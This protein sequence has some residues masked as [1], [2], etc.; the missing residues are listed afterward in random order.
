MISFRLSINGMCWTNKTDQSEDPIRNLQDLDLLL[1]FWCQIPQNMSCGVHAATNYNWF[2]SGHFQ[3]KS[4][5]QSNYF[6]SFSHEFSHNS[7]QTYLHFDV[8]ITLLVPYGFS[9]TFSVEHLIQ[10]CTRIL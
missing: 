9:R 3:L 7:L 6:Y 10:H 8:C 5:K 2:W 1:I 4:M